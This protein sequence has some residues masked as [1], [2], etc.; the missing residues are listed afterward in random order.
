MVTL[1]ADGWKNV[2][3]DSLIGYVVNNHGKV[4][5]LK[6]DDVSLLPK[7]GEKLFGLIDKQLQQLQTA[8]WGTQVIE[9]CTDNRANCK[10]A[11]KLLR[12]KYPWLIT[13]PCY[14]H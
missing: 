10:L 6:V 3:R 4:F 11:R 13:V 12:N 8:E 14:A 5:T 9:V 7:T 1:V 2:K